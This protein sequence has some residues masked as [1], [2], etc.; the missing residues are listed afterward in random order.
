VN[1]LPPSP[2]PAPPP[3]AANA[4]SLLLNAVNSPVAIAT[5]A[6]IIKIGVFFVIKSLIS[7]Y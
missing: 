2:L 6:I 7:Y 4:V 3:P 1:P 5:I